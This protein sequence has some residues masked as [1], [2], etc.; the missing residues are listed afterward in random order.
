MPCPP[1]A[2]IT[3]GNVT[4]SASPVLND[5]ATYQCDVG[6]DLVGSAIRTCVASG[7]GQVD[8]APGVP[9]CS[10]DLL[11]SLSVY[12]ILILQKRHL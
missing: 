5:N 12:I 9:A 3:D 4:V 6:H 11:S 7:P 2:N 10:G 8:W 1:P